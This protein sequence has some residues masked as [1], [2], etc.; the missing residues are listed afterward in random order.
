MGLKLDIIVTYTDKENTPLSGLVEVPTLI[1]LT[2]MWALG[3][4]NKDSS[5]VKGW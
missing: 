2:S 5:Y 3:P 4:K 1:A